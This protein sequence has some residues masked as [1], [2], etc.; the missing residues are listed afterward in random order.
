MSQD[1]NYTFIT[2][3]RGV[4]T[5]TI[6]LVACN[7]MMRA[8]TGV[9]VKGSVYG[10]GNLADVQVNTEVNMSAGTVEGNVFG[11]GKGVADNFTCDKAMVGT[12]DAGDPILHPEGYSDGNTT[13]TI[14]NGTV[15]GDVYGGGEV[16]RVEMNTTVT[17]GKAGDTS[18]TPIVKGHVFGAGAGVETHGYSALVRGNAT[19]TIQGKAQVWQNVHGGGEKASVGRYYVAKDQNDVDTYHVRIGMPCYLKAGGKC[20][21]NIQDGAVIGKD[22]QDDSGDVYGAGQGIRPN[23]IYDN[24]PSASYDDR[25]NYSKRMVNHVDYNETTHEGHNN[26]DKGKTWDYYVDDDGNEDTRY[27]W[28]YFTSNDDYLLYVET[29]ARA[30]ET[31]VVIGGKRETTGESA[32]NI[33]PSEDAP[34]INGS[35]YGGSESGFVYYGT[36]VNIPNGT[37]KGDAF[38]G[39][40]GLPSFVEAGRVKRNTSLTI[41][42]GAV[43]GNVYGGG[44][45]GDVGNIDKSDI[46]NYTWTNQDGNPNGTADEENTGVCTVIMTGGAVGKNGKSTANHASGHVFGAGKGSGDGT[47]YCEQGMVYKTNVSISK[48]TVYGNVYGGGQVGRVENNT[49][50]KI[51]P[52]SGEDVAE[53]KGSVFGAGA[54]LETHGYSALVRNNTDV[55]VQGYAKVR[56]NVYGGGEIAAVGRYWVRLEPPMDGA[57]TPPDGTVVGMPYQ[58]RS[59]GVCTVIVKGH[60]EIGPSEGAATEG[61]G[62]VF[63]AGKGVTPHYSPSESKKMLSTGEL[64]AFEDDTENHKTARELYYEFLETLALVTN[65]SVTIG[66]NTDASG[67]VKVKGSVFGG[68][69]NGFV[70][71]NTSVS[72]QKGSTIGSDGSTYG[73]VYGGGKGL[74]DFTAAGRVS[75]SSTVAIEDGTIWGSVYGGG[76]YGYVKENVTVNVTGGEV[77]KDVYGGGAM[78]HTNTANWTGS[79]LVNTYPYHEVTGLTVDESVVTGFFTES[80]GTYTKITAADTKAAEGATYYRLADTKVSLTGGK[81]VGNAYGGGLG[82]LG[83]AVAGVHYTQEEIDAAQEGDPAYGKTTENWKVEPVAASDGAGAVKA[84]VYG[85]V[86]VNLGDESKTKATA[87]TISHYTD[88]GYTDVVKSGRVFGCNNLNGSPKGNVTVTVYK[89]TGPEGSRTDSDK[90]TSTNASDH[91]YQLAAVYGGGNLADYIPAETSMKT[92]VKIMTCE[93]SVQEVYGGG[94][95]AA[96]PATDVLV[97]G[98]WE[99]NQVF[100]GGNGKDDYFLDEEWHTNPGANVGGDAITLLTGGYIHEAYGGSNSKGTISGD[101][102][103]S[104]GTGGECDLTVV[105][106]YGAGKDADVEGD[107]ILVMGC[108]DTR[109]EAVYGCSMNANVKGNV[110]LT[111][112]S[113]EYGKVFGGNNKSGAIFGHI[114]VNIEET[115]CTPI[116]IDELYGCGNDAAYSVYGYY[117]DGT[118]EGTDKPKY[119]ARTSLTDEHAAVTF[120][121][122]PH[123]DPGEN[124]YDDPEVN[125]YSCTRIGKVF[126]GGYGAGATVYGNP[127][128]NINQML[129]IKSDGNGGYITATELGRIGVDKN[130]SS[131]DCGVF[132][133]GN[134]AKVFGNTTINIGTETE[135]DLHASYDKTTGNYTY[136]E[137]QTVLG[138]NILSS[139]FGGGNEANVTGD[140]HVNIC[141]TQIVD[142]TKENGYTDTSVSHSETTGFAVSIGNSVYGGGNKADVEG[143]TFVTMADGYVF[144]GIFG[145]GLSGSVGTFTKSY[146]SDVTDWG[147]TAHANLDDCIGKPTACT[148]GGTCYVVVSGGQIGPLEVATHGMNRTTNGHGDPVPQGWVWGAGCG[149]VEDPSEEPDTH[150]KTYVNNTDVTIKGDAF[151]LESIIGG[152]EFGRVLGNTL[153]KIEG[154]QIGV[155]YNKVT[156]GKPVAYTDAQWTEAEAA[157]RAGDASRINAIA[158]AMPACSTFPYTSPYNTY[159]PYADLVTGTK[160]YPGGSTDNATDGKTWIGCVFAGGSGYMPYT[161]E[162]TDGNITDYDWVQSAGWVEGDAEVRISGGHILTNVYGGNENTDVKGTCRVT[163]TGGTVGVPRTVNQILANPMI[164]HVFGAGKGD[165]RVHFNKVTNVKDVEI[166]ISGGIVYG[167]VFGGGEDGHVLRDVKMTIDGDAKIGTW[168]TTYIDGNVFGGGRGYSGDAYTAGNVA[169]CVKVDIKGGQIL[170]SV[171]GGGQLG[172]VGYGLFDATTNGN[173]TPGYGEMRADSDTEEGFSTEGFF[174]NGRGHIDLTISGGTIGNSHEFIFPQTSNIPTGLSTDISAWTD[175]NWTTWKNH[176]NIPKTEFDTSTGRLS[177]TKGGNVFAGGMGRMYQLDDTTPISVVDWWKMGCVKSTKLTITGGTIKS[178]VFGGGELGQVVGYH[179]AKNAADADVNVG[180]EVIISGGTIGSEIKESGDVTRFIYGSIFGGGYGSLVE[181]LVH[182]ASTNPKKVSYPK[183]IAGRVKAGTKVNMT[184]GTVRASVYGGGKMAA[185]GESVVLEETL[186]DGLTGDTHVTIS[187]GTIGKSGFGGAKVGNVYGGGSGHN[188]TVRSGHVYGN[189]NVTISGADTRIYHNVYGGGAY[190]SVGDFVYSTGTDAQTGTQKVNGIS[191]L[192]PDHS[193]SGVATVTITGGTIGVNGKENGMVFGSSRGDINQPEERDDHTA[194]VYDA[195]VTIGDANGGP[196][197]K[198]SIYGS[199]ENGH[200]YNNAVVTINNGTIG[201]PSGEPITSNNGTPDDESDDITYEGAAYLYRGNV[202]GGGCGTDK[203]YADHTQETHDGNGQLFNP[204]AGIV[205][206]NATVNI[207][208]GTVVRNVYGAGAMGSVGKLNTDGTVTGGTTTI[209]ISGGTIGVDG[210][211]GD[212][213]VF[214][215]A[216]GNVDAISN[217]AALVRKATDVSIT[218]G[219]IKGNVY[220]GGELGCVGVY[221]ISSD[222]RTFTWKNTDGTTAA[223][224][225][226][227]NTGICNVIIDGSSAVIN[228]HVFGAGKGKDDTFWCE[229]GIAYSTNVSIQNGTIAKNVYG[230]GEVGRVETDTEVKVGLAPEEGTSE[231]TINGSVFGGGAGVETHGYSALVRG[232]T[233]VTVDQNAHVAH[234]VYGGGEIASVGKYGLDAQNMPSI[235]QGGGYC[236]VTVQGN[237]A[238]AEDVFGAGKGVTPHFDKDNSDETKRSRRMT[239]KNDW[240]ERVGAD[241]FTWNYLP[242]EAAYS[243]YLETLALATHP[244]VTIDGSAAI[245]GSVFGGGELG[246]TKGSVV[247]NIQGG[248]INEDVYGGGKLANSNTTSSVDLD[249]NGEIETVHPTTTL[250]LYGGLINGDAYGGG[251]GQKTGF[252]DA[253]GAIA[254]SD[255]EATVY[256]NITVNLGSI[257]TPAIEETPAVLG[258]ATAF[259]IRYE[260]TGDKDE[261]N[262]PIKV[263][264]SGRVFGC[265]NLNGS[266]QGNVT[267]NVYKTVEGTLEGVR[268]TRTASDYYKLKEDDAGY[269]APTYELA[270]VYGGGNL[271]DYTATDKKASVIIHTCDVSVQHVYGGGNAAAV[272]ETDVLVKGAYEIEHVFGGGNGKDMYKRANEW[273]PNPGA[274]VLTNTNTLLIG[275]YIHEA[276]GG[277]NESGTISGNVT[278]NTD[279]KDARCVCDLELVKL[280]GAGKNAD[281]DGDLIVVLDC[282]P[283]TKTEEI[284]GGAE[285]AN[286]RGNVE[287]TITSGSFGKV[288]GG[289]NQSGAIFG[290]I[291]L[292]IE[293]TSC[294]PIIIDELYGCGNNAAYSVYGYKEGTDADGY[295]IYVPRTSLD[296]G[297]A[298]T[299]NKDENQTAHTTP[300]YADP[301]VNIISCTS[302][303]KVFGGGYGSGATVY[304]NPTVNIN[305]IY[306]KAYDGNAYTATATTLGEIGE[307]FGGGNEANVVGNTTVNVGTVSTVQLH[308]SYDKTTGYSMSGNQTVIGANITGNVYGGGNQAEVT[309]NTNVNIGRSVTPTP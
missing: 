212:G 21:V 159:D 250:N 200:T 77:K 6:L 166:N 156:D 129:G 154:G 42:G 208:G 308:Q 58:Q 209:N 244:E 117:Q 75:E 112:T 16:G 259:N 87:F 101:I 151:I 93:V 193:N 142:Q 111:I 271:A 176:N 189:T 122:K 94:N 281:I 161:K 110:E 69:E 266:P 219:T 60:A 147:H 293:E 240:K 46:N 221:D 115:G 181:E 70:Q 289:N 224:S 35:V 59:G 44:S 65:T 270:A 192:H 116:I 49:T 216:R 247:V 53:I 279:S 79:A 38:G 24:P 76:T 108:S 236:Y 9:R 149:L 175:E 243:T 251:L 262:Q 109:T 121:G 255:I 61:A 284:Y 210:T 62:H 5:A 290:H 286:V 220:G 206:G 165:P 197:I 283:E 102:N 182:D 22:G 246:L 229:K 130:G 10:G 127:K 258:P 153:V 256:G 305:Q 183:Y 107:L 201:I 233:T 278:I 301:Q 97:N 195:N 37:V 113:G 71:H 66:D 105:E 194:W 55:T 80:S 119:V 304:G 152:G 64:V 280:Y 134:Q 45:L 2:T 298:V 207:N 198:G 99:I 125:I 239:L 26:N 25:K 276:Y 123:T 67:G 30:S 160:P 48:G 83:V 72:V 74:S 186:T 18:L 254:T 131:D 73:N 33:T 34:T 202:Y 205:Y 303:G 241:R 3:L 155:G 50:V 185:V 32:G 300:K 98:A 187:G 204:L 237:A 214:G 23:W 106:L 31:D 29:L 124:G 63:G 261:A 136:I 40:K 20:T 180:T 135:V 226:N 215:A 302:I 137:N 114:I 171:Y 140:T 86:S 267:V 253:N 39:G 292:N 163:M 211:K 1:R 27:V 294:R 263:V 139:V 133:G 144:N 296:D 177:H 28:E 191:N 82:K 188:N 196:A 146:N 203:Y 92:K 274:N 141:G 248:T 57:P 4:L 234:S 199:G 257:E 150:F 307:V 68:S 299:F 242:D 277:S 138:A 184:D 162:D 232:N 265:N 90:K 222:Y 264:Q 309:G 225:D 54:G 95:A 306:G 218:G 17:I 287:L 51:G 100:G 143:N 173:P 14:T 84:M 47:Y 235:L 96:V 169:G 213:N 41:S 282:A 157:V 167:S 15:Q 217:E 245:S 172:S 11:G 89:T 126:G 297:V 227:K 91:K 120:E 273:I 269:V 249:G 272:P 190:G 178:T 285:N 85:D 36:L 88:E 238:I 128:V 268:N 43:E 12:V 223:N 103:I 252:Y 174:T 291:I 275:G 228:G 145:G 13:V 179:T 168:G 56:N 231:P 288:F 19:V 164:G 132:G 260:D 158:A 7:V 52:D 104:K 78:A 295:K 81:I 230:G 148:S 118:I 8:Q 170:G